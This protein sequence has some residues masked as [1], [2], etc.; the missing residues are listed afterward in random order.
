MPAGSPMVKIT[1][2]EKLDP[3]HKVEVATTIVAEMPSD[4]EAR[5][6]LLAVEQEIYEEDAPEADDGQKYVVIVTD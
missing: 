2:S 5:K 4:P 6:K 3:S 1:E